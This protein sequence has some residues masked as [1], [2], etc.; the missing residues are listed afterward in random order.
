MV[1]GRTLR[2][3]SAASVGSAVA[4]SP[5]TTATETWQGPPIDQDV[6]MPERDRILEAARRYT[7]AFV[8][9]SLTAAPT[10]KIVVLT[11]MDARLDLFRLLGLELLRY[12]PE[13][14]SPARAL[15]GKAQATETVCGIGTSTE[16]A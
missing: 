6:R 12:H 13:Y 14:Q 8:P 3:A 16:F 7:D 10:R 11:C 1:R 4:E 2:R 5:P 9:N 15:P